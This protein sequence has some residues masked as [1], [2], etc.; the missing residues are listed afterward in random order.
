MRKSY[1][2]RMNL[3]PS[4]KRLV[5]AI[6]LVMFVVLNWALVIP[7]FSDWGKVQFRMNKARRTLTAFDA[8]IRQMPVY[9]AQV[10]Q[11]GSENSNIA[12]AEQQLHFANT[13]EAVA[14]S[15]GV[16]IASASR[17][18]T[19]TNQF[20]MELTQSINLL[21]K[22]P[23]LVTF[24]HS[25]GSGNSLIRVRDLS[26]RPDAQRYNLNSS[27]KLAA[28]YQKRP[29]AARTT[30]PAQTRIGS[31][32]PART[33]APAP[34]PRSIAASPAKPVVPTASPA[35]QTLNKP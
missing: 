26:L 17:V 13:R 27:V 28:S 5:V 21:C 12:I 22:E 16:T 15:A 14:A 32:A 4:E 18:T 3:R 31:P 29:P 10:R 11:L 34:P 6:A 1:L 9:Q 30:A 2:D 25:L 8:E 20:F 23:E 33:N 24:L 7:H 35:P 19:R